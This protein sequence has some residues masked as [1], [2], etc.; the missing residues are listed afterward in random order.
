MKLRLIIFG[1]IWGG[2]LTSCDDGFL[3]RPAEDKVEAP[4]FFNTAKDLEVATND[5]YNAFSKDSKGDE[6]T[7]VYTEDAASD[8][9]MTLNPAARVRGSRVVPVGRGTGGWKWDDLR[10]INYFLKNYHKVQDEAAKAKYG[11][12]AR[13]FRAYFYYDKVKTFGDVPWYS[14]VLDAKDPELYKARD[15]RML[16]MDSVMADLDFAIANIPAEKQVNLITRYTAMLLKARIALFEGTFRRYHG[17]D[18]ADQYLTLAAEAAQALIATN[19]YTLHTE[20]GAEAAYRNL[21]ARNKQDNIETILA[22]DF[23]LGLKVHSL[24]YSFTSA[25]Q[26]SYGLTKDL[27]NSYLMRDGSR[28][29]DKSNYRTIGFFEEMQNR[30]PRLNQTTAGP[31]FRVNGET[32]N[33]P[34][35]LSITTTGYRL[36][37]ALPER[38]QWTTSGTYFDI[39]MFRYAEALLVLAEAKAELGTLTQGDLNISINR[40]RTRVGM[41]NL[42]MA[43][44]NAQPDP[45]LIAMY[46]NTKNDRGMQGVILEIRRERRAELFNEG[47]RW[48]DLM[49][50][51]EGL[52]LMQPMVGVYLPGVGAYDFTGDGQADVFVHTGNTTG[53]PSSV[54]SMVNISQRTLRNPITGIQGAPSGNIDPFPDNGKFREDRDYLAPIPTEEL[55]LNENL[56]Q[57]PKWEE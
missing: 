44:A 24:G 13:F 50:W 48:D 40:L 32:K 55:L 39:I 37:K 22:I 57:N 10:K 2:I 20:G 17:L 5:F 34:V 25:T 4:Y 15:S 16:V 43:Q 38:A 14:G 27:V 29:T 21:F 56:R 6:W 28:F 42:D 41:P 1:I 45:Y 11:G 8:N 33:E 3:D 30:D 26:G 12:I 51:K 49:R 36:I 35:N 47:F 7:E 19:A 52:K 54:T 23:E 53:A 46:P 31:E 9:M 18:G